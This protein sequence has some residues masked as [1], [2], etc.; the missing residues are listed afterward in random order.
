MT[1]ARVWIQFDT[2]QARERAAGI[3][4]NSQAI[5]NNGSRGWDIPLPLIYSVLQALHSDG[6]RFRV[7]VSS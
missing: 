6:F 2:A 3:V 7:E 5:A 1:A 4:P